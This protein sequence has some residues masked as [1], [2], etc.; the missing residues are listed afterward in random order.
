M[1]T[2][3][4]HETG[5]A[6]AL[7][8]QNIMRRS[9]LVLDR[10]LAFIRAFDRRNADLHDGLE[11]I[12][13]HFVHA[14]A[15]WHALRDDFWV[16]QDLPDPIPWCVERVIAFDLQEKLPPRSSEPAISTATRRPKA[17]GF[18]RKKP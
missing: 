5:S 11:L 15:S 17:T 12:R 18:D 16:Q 8:A 6:R 4:L 2:S 7:P 1:A 10:H 3:P 13:R 14:L 9:L